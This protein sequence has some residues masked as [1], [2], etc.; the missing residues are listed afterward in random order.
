VIVVMVSGDWPWSR[1]K[2]ASKDPESALNR[3]PGS[4]E[5]AEIKLAVG[6]PRS[7]LLPGITSEQAKIAAKMIGSQTVLFFI[8]ADKTE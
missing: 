1:R 3:S 5:R 6:A 2:S 8:L 7:A 4:V